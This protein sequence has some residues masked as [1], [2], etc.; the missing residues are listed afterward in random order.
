MTLPVVLWLHSLGAIN[1]A[2]H[3]NQQG[4]GMTESFDGTILP[5]VHFSRIDC[6]V[7]SGGVVHRVIYCGCASRWPWPI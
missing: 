4:G 5:L 3:F 6:I 2:V 1:R 7:P